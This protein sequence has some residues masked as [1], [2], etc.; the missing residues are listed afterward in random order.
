MGA[1]AAGQE[2]LG[3]PLS[4]QSAALLQAPG[5]LHDVP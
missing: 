1:S 4:S 3:N 2:G 5:A